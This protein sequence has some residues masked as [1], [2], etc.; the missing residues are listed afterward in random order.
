VNTINTT[1]SSSGLRG[2]FIALVRR[3][4]DR[5]IAYLNV[6]RGLAI[7]LV[8]VS[9]FFGLFKL[10]FA[11]CGVI[12]FF[13]LSGYLMDQTLVRDS[14]VTPF[15]IRRTL[16]ILPMYWVSI[17]LVLAS[18]SA[19]TIRDV[20]ANATFMAPALHSERMLG[21]YWTLYIE[22]LFY[23]VVPFVR[24]LGERSIKLAPY[25]LI[26]IFCTMYAVYGAVNDAS[27]YILFCFG[28]MQIGAWSRGQNSRLQLI[29]VFGAICVSASLLPT[30]GIYFG[31]EPLFCMVLF[32]TAMRHSW[33]FR[34]LEFIGDVS[35]SWYLLHTLIG[36]W[37]MNSLAAAGAK[38]W[39][40]TLVGILVSI[41]ASIAAFLLIEQPMIQLGKFAV[42]RMSAI[43]N[44]SAIL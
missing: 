29:L 8:V 16:R 18:G 14:R 31:L 42:G 24:F 13:F 36:F 5:R 41:V 3:P 35:Y 10:I 1:A 21:V 38:L 23:A 28:G 15:M 26:G 44:R 32:L 12:L 30:N 11:N 34:P 37:T 4:S 40:A 7:I 33:S 17:L 20:L 25:V 19:W 6:L 39:A 9:H 2:R 43:Q 22:V 27:F